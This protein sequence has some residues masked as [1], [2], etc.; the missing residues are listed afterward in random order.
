MNDQERQE[1]AGTR[2]DDSANGVFS[3]LA[4]KNLT[5]GTRDVRGLINVRK[6][7]SSEE[8]REVKVTWV[9]SN[10]DPSVTNK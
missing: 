9:D 5:L 1:E 4:L 7:L 8:I 2:I 6:Q 3:F 10:P